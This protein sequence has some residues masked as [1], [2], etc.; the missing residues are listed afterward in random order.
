M[1]QVILAVIAAVVLVGCQNEVVVE[2][3]GYNSSFRVLDDQGLVLAEVD[4]I[5]VGAG[6]RTS[7]VALEDLKRDY[8][9]YIDRGVEQIEV[10]RFDSVYAKYETSGLIS[11]S[12]GVHVTDF[13]YT[14]KR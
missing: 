8:S 2:A 14:D 1:R 6:H 10:I 13:E 9:V 12:D 4:G 11:V 3:T 7:H 5:D